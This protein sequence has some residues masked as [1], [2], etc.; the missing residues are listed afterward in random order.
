MLLKL[1]FCYHYDSNKIDS[2]VLIFLY[3]CIQCASNLSIQSARH[4]VYLAVRTKC[5]FQYAISVFEICF[6]QLTMMSTTKYFSA[7]SLIADSR[8]LAT[9]LMVITSGSVGIELP[10]DSIE[11]DEENSKPNGTTLLYILGRG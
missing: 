10:M 5:A 8:E 1:F 6:G 9:G 2:S 7:G 4:L 3:N 11:A